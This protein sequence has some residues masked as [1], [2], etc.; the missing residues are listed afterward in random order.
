MGVVVEENVVGV[1]EIGVHGKRDSANL[2]AKENFELRG[3]D[4]VPKVTSTRIVGGFSNQDYTNYS[5]Y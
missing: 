2:M 5:K 3:L 4:V 1:L